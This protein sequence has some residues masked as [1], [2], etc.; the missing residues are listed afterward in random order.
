MRRSRARRDS[1][2][3]SGDGRDAAP[4]K[5]A[6]VAGGEAVEVPVEGGGTVRRVRG[7]LVHALIL[8]KGTA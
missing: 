4:R 1:E 5:P 8:T 6:P 2:E 7:K 3:G